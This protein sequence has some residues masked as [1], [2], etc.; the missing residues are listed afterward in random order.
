MRDK[1]DLSMIEEVRDGA[2]NET[3]IQLHTIRMLGDVLIC[4]PVVKYSK[5]IEPVRQKVSVI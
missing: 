3:F 4:L 1:A 2:Q 5:Q